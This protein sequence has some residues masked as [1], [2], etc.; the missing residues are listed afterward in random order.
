MIIKLVCLLGITYFTLEFF[1]VVYNTFFKVPCF[2]WLLFIYFDDSCL[3][4]EWIAW[5]TNVQCDKKG[6]VSQAT[7]SGFF[8][9]AQEIFINRYK[10]SSVILLVTIEWNFIVVVC[11]RFFQYNNTRISR[12]KKYLRF[13]LICY[14]T[15]DIGTKFSEH[16]TTVS[17][18][19]YSLILLKCNNNDASKDIINV[20]L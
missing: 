1:F 19:A 18:V 14:F 15:P 8:L 16:L 13:D 3:Q 2:V 17:S 11:S 9:W 4:I 10:S 7:Q 6:T 20:S 5:N 12:S